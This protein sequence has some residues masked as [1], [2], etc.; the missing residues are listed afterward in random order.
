MI[1]SSARWAT[2]NAARYLQ[3]LCKHFAH[4]VEVSHSETEGQVALMT[5]PATLR[6]EDA[7][8]WVRVSAP[9]LK[10][11]IAARHAIDSHL[12]TFA[13]REHFAGMPWALDP[14]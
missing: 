12:V 3:Q 5:G 8:L 13:F 11:I 9:D 14:V 6:A 10:G 1:T 4:R 7:A 2:P